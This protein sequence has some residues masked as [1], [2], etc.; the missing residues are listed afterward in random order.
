MPVGGTLRSAQGAD[1]E[2]QAT[3]QLESAEQ[4]DASQQKA[5]SAR[6][7]Y[8][9]RQDGVRPTLADGVD[10]GVT[11]KLIV[12]EHVVDEAPKYSPNEGLL[13]MS[14]VSQ[15]DPGLPEVLKRVVSTS[16][17]I[18]LVAAL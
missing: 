3:P 16:R 2:L 15:P 13:P 14:V 1:A 11:Q 6:L 12:D 4:P 10:L 8:S 9:P 5:E 18:E 17:T 7:R